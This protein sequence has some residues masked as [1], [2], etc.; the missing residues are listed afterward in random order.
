MVVPV[1]AGSTVSCR[2]LP[3]VHSAG[4]QVE[5]D[6]SLGGERPQLAC[7]PGGR[8]VR[9]P[10]L[11]RQ[12]GVAEPDR[13][14]GPGE[15]APD[16]AER[17][18]DGPARSELP[19]GVAGEADGGGFRVVHVTDYIGYMATES[20]LPRGT[21][22]WID[23]SDGQHWWFDAGSI[24][25]DFAYTGGLDRNTPE[26]ETVHDARELNEWLDRALSR[27]RPDRR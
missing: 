3:C 27:G 20:I 17:R 16:G 11:A 15:V 18:A 6:A 19:P 26:W 2:V 5:T 7:R 25:L 14:S 1:A 10:G 4:F 22:Q 21:G 12:G 9:L 8:A 13:Q 24:A 23:S